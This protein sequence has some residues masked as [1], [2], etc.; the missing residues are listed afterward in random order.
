VHPAVANL[1]F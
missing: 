1:R